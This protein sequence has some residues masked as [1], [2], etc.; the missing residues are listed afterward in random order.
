MISQREGGVALTGSNSRRGFVWR[1]SGSDRPG[2]FTPCR[3]GVS[4]E[5]AVIGG[6]QMFAMKEEKICNL[7]MA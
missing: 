5:L 2:D 1:V 6:G 4:S 3:D 7:A